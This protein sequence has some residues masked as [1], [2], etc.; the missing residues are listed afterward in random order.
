[1][2]HPDQINVTYENF[3]ESLEKFAQIIAP[4]GHCAL[5]VS[6]WGMNART[7]KEWFYQNDCNYFE[8]V[9]LKQYVIDQVLST[10][11]ITVTHLDVEVDINTFGGSVDGDI[12]IVFQKNHK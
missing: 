11:G 9:K 12:K 2:W 10:P 1:M 5:S 7:S 6:V 4:G 8:G 3:Q